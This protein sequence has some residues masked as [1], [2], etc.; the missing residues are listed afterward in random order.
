[1]GRNG[2]ALKH[3]KGGSSGRVRETYG[4]RYSRLGTEG[5]SYFSTKPCIWS[6]RRKP[7]MIMAM[8]ATI[9]VELSGG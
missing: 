6:H 3:P 5:G 7:I 8:V 2:H 1:M 9:R 4:I